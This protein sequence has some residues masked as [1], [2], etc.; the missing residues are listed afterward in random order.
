MQ[1]MCQDLLRL[2]ECNQGLGAEL[3][4]VKGLGWIPRRPFLD[5]C[6]LGVFS[7]SPSTLG[8]S[9]DPLHLWHLCQL[10][11][12]TSVLLHPAQQAPSS[13]AMLQPVDRHGK[14]GR[15]ALEQG[16]RVGACS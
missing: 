11:S 2:Q 14:L 6:F 1:A 16:A 10:C 4:A 9:P 12:M 3:A 5:P 15:A 7:G 8:C 13:A